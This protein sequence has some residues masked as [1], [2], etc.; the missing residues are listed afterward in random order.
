[1]APEHTIDLT[2]PPD[3]RLLEIGELYRDDIQLL[4][5]RTRE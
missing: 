3:K 1:M 2:L 4:L 5:L